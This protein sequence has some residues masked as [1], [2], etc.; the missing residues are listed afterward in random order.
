MRCEGSF[1]SQSRTDYKIKYSK[2]HALYRENERKW[3]CSR[4]KH[5]PSRICTFADQTVQRWKSRRILWEML[6]L[7]R[8]FGYAG[9]HDLSACAVPRVSNR[10]SEFL[11]I[12]WKVM[13]GSHQCV[14]CFIRT[15]HILPK[16]ALAITVLAITAVGIDFKW[17]PRNIWPLWEVSSMSVC[18]R[19]LEALLTLQ[20]NHAFKYHQKNCNIVHYSSKVCA[21]KKKIREKCEFSTNFHFNSCDCSSKLRKRRTLVSVIRDPVVDSVILLTTWEICFKV[22][23]HLN[24]IHG[25]H[26]WKSKPRAAFNSRFPVQHEGSYTRA[27]LAGINDEETFV[28]SLPIFFRKTPSDGSR[29]IWQFYWICHRVCYIR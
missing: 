20:P 27:Q 29:Q 19:P 16:S 28:H 3:A 8:T 22:D 18:N 12:R 10:R 4:K 2:V 13:G 9:H 25:G 21:A 6:H 24:S 11:L 1:M 7:S 14:S 23:S 5:A 17:R 15:H 26:G